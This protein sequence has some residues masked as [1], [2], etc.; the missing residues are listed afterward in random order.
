MQIY[1]E[2]HKQW[3]IQLYVVLSAVH[4]Q[5]ILELFGRNADSVLGFQSNSEEYVLSVGILKH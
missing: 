5:P 3:R 4:K 2:M 1:L